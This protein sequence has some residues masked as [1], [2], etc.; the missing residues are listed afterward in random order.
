ML[1]PSEWQGRI[2]IVGTSPSADLQPHQPWSAYRSGNKRPLVR[3][4]LSW[5]TMN[6]PVLTRMR[7]GVGAGGKKS[8][9]PY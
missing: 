3:I 8:P 4:S 1:T 7:G 6:R 5:Y 2:P 9:A